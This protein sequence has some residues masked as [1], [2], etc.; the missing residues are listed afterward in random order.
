[1][2]VQLEAVSK[3]KDEDKFY[4][5]KY[6]DYEEVKEVAYTNLKNLKSEKLSNVKSIF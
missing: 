4:I 3:L 2:L 5:V 6:A 1:M